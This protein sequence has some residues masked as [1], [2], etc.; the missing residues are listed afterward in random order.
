MNYQRL[1]YLSNTAPYFQALAPLGKRVWLD[2]GKPH[3]DYGRY[4]ILSAAPIHVLNNPTIEI[5]ESHVAQLHTASAALRQKHP[6]LPFH[7]GA[8]GYFNYEHNAAEFGITPHHEARPSIVGIFN[9]ALIQDHKEKTAHLLFLESCDKHVSQKIT[10]QLTQASQTL[11]TEFSVNNLTNDISREHY[12]QNID[13]I[14][15]HILA[16]DSYQVNFSQRFSGDFEGASDAAYLTLRQVMPSPFSAYCELGDDDILSLSPERF[17]HLENHIATTQP[18]KGTIARGATKEE[19]DVLANTLLNSEKNRAENVMIV[20]LLR[21]DFSQSCE[22]FS[23][24]VPKLFALESFANVH[25]LVSTV[26]G[27]VKA[28]VSPLTFF[29]RCFP[30]GSITGAPKKRAMEIIRDLETTP[31]NIYC[32]S[33][34]YLSTNGKLDSNIAIRTLLVSEEKIYCWGGGGIVFDSQAGEEYDESLQKIA[35]LI[36]TLKRH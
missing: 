14:H 36:E 23:V 24:K 18:I 21:N 33:V 1:P 10:Q 32:G 15:E 35:V 25:H 30:G 6:H 4:D 29:M 19:D 2:S 9:W 3:S 27:K 22:P 28:D 12:I 16:G 34:F 5:I 8:I 7:G 26:E 20:D 11:A 31:R 17:I 13:R